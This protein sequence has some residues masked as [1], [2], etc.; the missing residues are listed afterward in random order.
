MATDILNRIVQRKREEIAAARAKISEGRLAEQAA[1]VGERRSLL[2]SLSRP[3]PMGA[4]IIAEVKRGSPSKGIIRADLDAAKQAAAYQR[5]GAAAVSVLTDR[6]FFHGGPEDLVAARGAIDLPVLRKDFT[7]ST[8]QIFEAAAMGADAIL[9]IVRILEPEFIRDALQIVSELGMDALVETHSAREV[10]TAMKAGA[11]IIGINN[12]DL[13]V[14]KTD[15][16]TS[17]DLVRLLEPGHVPVSESGIHGRAEVDRLAEAGI[18]NFLIGESLVRAEKPEEM[19]RELMPGPLPARPQVK[20]C[21]LTD[22]DEAAQVAALGADAVGVVFYPPSPRNVDEERARAICGALPPGVPGV[23][24]FVNESFDGVM[25]K[26]ERCGLGA[27]QLH[28]NESVEMAARL[29]ERGITVIK[30]V[31]INKEP[32]LKDAS[33][34]PASAFLVEF[35]G[36]TLPGGNG[37]AWDWSSVMGAAR[38]RPLIL[39]GGLTP[40]NVAEA[41]RAARPDAVDVS[42]GVESAPGRKSMD[43]VKRFL[44]A[45]LRSGYE[46]KPGRV[47]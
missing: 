6:D 21:G 36:G 9:L 23:G 39:A 1:S 42:S 41:V 20:V 46:G 47:F 12:R 8:Y 30:G 19:L 38:D 43:K 11:R 3:G 16:Q 26:V 35:A 33:A 40:E 17:I 7:V 15:I 13:S 44:E 14:F 29:R 37:A 28:G 2:R 24:V 22:P 5:G 31:Y 25:R 4:N 45:V 10:E 18:R 32:Y 34:Y 27:V